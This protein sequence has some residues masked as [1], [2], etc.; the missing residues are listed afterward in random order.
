MTKTGDPFRDYD[1]WEGIQWNEAR[2]RPVCEV[3]G[4][5]IYED[6]AFRIGYDLWCDRCIQDSKEYID[7][8]EEE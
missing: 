1:R 4:A 3:C 2:K 5:P 6:Y 7:D 8:I